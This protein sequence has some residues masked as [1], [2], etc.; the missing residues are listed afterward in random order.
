MYR[1][2]ISCFINIGAYFFNARTMEP[3]KQSL[4][5]KGRLTLKLHFLFKPAFSIQS[6]PKVPSRLGE[7]Q[8]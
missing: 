7:S 1:I 8:I 3:E 4:L 2:I 6:V 5:G